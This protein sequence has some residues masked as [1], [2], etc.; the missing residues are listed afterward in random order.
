MPVGKRELRPHGTEAAYRRHLAAGEEPCDP[1]K[2]GHREHY[3]EKNRRNGHRPF[4]KVAAELREGR[5][6]T[7]DCRLESHAHR[8]RCGTALDY[9]SPSRQKGNNIC[10]Q[11]RPDWLRAQRRDRARKERKGKEKTCD[12]RLR[13]HPHPG[14]CGAGLGD[15]AYRPPSR[16]KRERHNICKRCLPDWRAAQMLRARGVVALGACGHPVKDP[17]SVL[18]P[19]CDNANR[20]P[21]ADLQRLDE[22]LD[23]L[24]DRGANISA[25]ALEKEAGEGVGWYA[26]NA[27]LKRIKAGEPHVPAYKRSDD[28]DHE[29]SEYNHKLH[30]QKGE[31]CGP[32]QSKYNAAHKERA[33]D[34]KAGKRRDG[35]RLPI[36]HGTNAGW[37]AHKRRGEQPC[38]ECEAAHHQDNR[39]RGRRRIQAAQEG[40]PTDRRH[41]P[42]R[43]GTN[44]GWHAHKRHGEE[45]CPDCL[46]AHR[47]YDREGS[48]RRRQAAAI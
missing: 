47:R 4:A 26:A 38:V 20:T 43:H 29:A 28:L 41:R 48:R 34:R 22:A 8:G 35:R 10:E 37:Q 15:R 33:R 19:K 14:R 6:V 7:C 44:A 12:C 32:C 39:E 21:R 1:C 31:T 16:L 11:C 25:R 23:R 17:R 36:R 2:A 46:E 13:A 18:C 30:R 9:R 40:R 27:Y 3:T 24:R 5:E 42:I 45:P